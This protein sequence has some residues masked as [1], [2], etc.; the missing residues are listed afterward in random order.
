[1]IADVSRSLGEP[2]VGRTMEE[3]PAEQLLHTRGW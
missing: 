3:I 2:M 1:M